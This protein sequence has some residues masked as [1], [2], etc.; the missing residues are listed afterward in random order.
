MKITAY[1]LLVIGLLTGIFAT[2]V[3]KPFEQNWLSLM[4]GAL[5]F[6]IIALYLLELPFYLLAI[7][8]ILLF[9]LAVLFIFSMTD[10]PILMK[11]AFIFLLLSIILLLVKYIKRKF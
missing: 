2:Q 4:I 10:T 11:I 7:L 6:I 5:I 3:G 8:L 1:I 9:I